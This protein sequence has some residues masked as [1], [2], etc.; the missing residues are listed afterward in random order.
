MLKLK[1]TFA[2]DTKIEFAN[3]PI[4]LQVDLAGVE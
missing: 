2:M 4:L 1:G 3:L